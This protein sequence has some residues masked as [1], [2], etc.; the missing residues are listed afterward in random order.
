MRGRVLA[1]QAMLF[2]GST[3]IGGPIVGWVA[4]T[5]GA[6]WALML[7]A[8]ACLGAGTWGLM[9]VRRHPGT[10]RLVPVPTGT[11]PGPE[12]PGPPVPESVGPGPTPGPPTPVAPAAA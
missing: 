10:D 2:L 9:V 6:R 1:L 12:R 11:G 8:V 4:Q 7:G 5:A 3:P